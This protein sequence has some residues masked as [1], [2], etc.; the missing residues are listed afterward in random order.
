MKLLTSIV[1]LVSFATFGLDTLCTHPIYP[2]ITYEPNEYNYYKYTPRYIPES[3]LHCFKILGTSGDDVL[4]RFMQRSEEEVVERGMFEAAYRI[5]KEF[6]LESF[7]SFSNFFVRRG[8]Y[9]PYAMKTYIL[10]CFH[11]YLNKEKIKW[12]S[13]KRTA[14]KDLDKENKAWKRRYKNVFVNSPP[15]QDDPSL[16]IVGDTTQT[17]Y[18]NPFVWY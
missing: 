8:I 6:C 18:T 13:N 17:D 14:L 12:H 3:M 9:Y 7:S 10:L 15:M 16:K 4:V 2:P 5:R 11:Q 1:C